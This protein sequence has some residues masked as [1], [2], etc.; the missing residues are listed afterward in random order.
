[1]AKKR[2]KKVSGPKVKRP[3]PDRRLLPT[4]FRKYLALFDTEKVVDESANNQRGFFKARPE[5]KGKQDINIKDFLAFYFDNKE[6]YNLVRGFF[7]LSS[8]ARAHPILDEK[9]LVSL[10]KEKVG[11]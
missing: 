2:S 3:A 9:K 1:M 4:D 10:V 7:E 11:A 8:H 5:I 6:D